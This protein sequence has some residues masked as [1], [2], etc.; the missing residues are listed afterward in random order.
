MTQRTR[1]V[2]WVGEDDPDRL[3]A[4]TIRLGDDRLSAIGTSR[5]AE[6]ATSWSLLTGP[7]W[8][9]ERIEVSAHGVGWS[10]WLRLDRD[11]AGRWLST[12]AQSGDPD[13]VPRGIDRTG[14]S[15]ATDL[16][17]VH[18]AATDVEVA[19]L[20]GTDL[21]GTAL[22]GTALE[23]ALD[24]DLAFCPVTN[25]MPILRLRM[26]ERAVERTPLVMAWI[27]VP[28][29]RVV[30]SEQIYSSRGP[31]TGDEG[32]ITYESRD[33]AFRS[34]LT[35]DGDGIVIAYPQLARRVD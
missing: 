17:V 26:L 13:L 20:E 10:R 5:T 32:V 25:T 1:I 3:D 11:A 35:V 31:G 24:C 27:D 30:R 21:G 14:N 28:S 12:V 18:F 34:E 29:L 4:A 33:G 16:E 9:T 23:G 7:H 6:Y 19:G 22:E 8:I 15:A 2:H